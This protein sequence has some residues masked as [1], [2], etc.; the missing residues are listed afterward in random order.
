MTKAERLGIRIVIPEEFAALV[1]DV[2][3]VTVTG[4]PTAAAGGDALGSGPLAPVDRGEGGRGP[5]QQSAAISMPVL[6]SRARGAD[7]CIVGPRSRVVTGKWAVTCAGCGVRNCRIVCRA[8]T[9]R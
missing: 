1:A 2:L 3:D 9:S 4:C 7:G 8:L 6:R 5:G